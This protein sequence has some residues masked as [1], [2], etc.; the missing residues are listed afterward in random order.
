MPMIQLQINNFKEIATCPKLHWLEEE[1]HQ[2][3]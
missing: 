2:F 1:G 3:W